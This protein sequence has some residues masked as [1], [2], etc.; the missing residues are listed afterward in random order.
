MKAIAEDVVPKEI[1]AFQNY[2]EKK[3]RPIKSVA[4]ID[5]LSTTRK[6][7]VGE[8]KNGV[9]VHDTIIISSLTAQDLESIPCAACG[10]QS[11]Y[12]LDKREDIK[13]ANTEEKSIWLQ[14]RHGW[15][16]EIRRV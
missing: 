11:L 13:K 7:K 2:L 6:K 3:V 10:H 5:K 4:E 9:L 15:I 14:K 16:A 1:T 12:A 8:Q